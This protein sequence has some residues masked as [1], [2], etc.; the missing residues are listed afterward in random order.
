MST[1]E[2][3]TQRLW[4]PYLT[5]ADKAALAA[6]PPRTPYTLR[7]ARRPALL[8]V[9]LYRAVFGDRPEPLI[10]ALERWPSSCGPAAWDA[11]PHIEQLLQVCRSLGLPVVHVAGLS[12]SGMTGWFRRGNHNLE[13]PRRTD[14]EPQVAEGYEIMDTVAPAPG[15]V[16]LYKTAPSAFWG[17]P[18][19][20]HLTDQGVDTIVVCGETTS[21][22]VRATVVDACSAR[23]NV[24]V[25]EDCVFDRHEAPHAINLF[26]MHMKYADVLPLQEVFTMLRL[27]QR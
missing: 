10:D 19:M 7:N 16:V 21:G 3:V 14:V 8:L 24:I 18:L 23:L 20:A 22:C 9:D 13:E 15:E 12:G 1:G 11:L 5:E 2:T 6:A 26:D 4:E 17:T 25:P 27:L